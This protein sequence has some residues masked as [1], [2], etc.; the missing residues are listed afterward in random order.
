MS[1][2]TRHAIVIERRLQGPPES[3]RGGYIYDRAGRRHERL[4][5]RHGETILADAQATTLELDPP[6]HVELAAAQAADSRCL[7]LAHHPFSTCFRCG[8]NRAE[9]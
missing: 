6:P 7:G 4:L 3:G 2:A 9:G 1:A 8:L 5:L